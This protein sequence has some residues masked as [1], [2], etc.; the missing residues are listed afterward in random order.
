[1]TVTITVLEEYLVSFLFVW[2]NNT[3][4][5][6]L[7]MLSNVWWIMLEMIAIPASVIWP[8]SQISMDVI[9][10]T[11][12][13]R[14]LPRRTRSGTKRNCLTIK[15]LY[16]WNLLFVL[17]VFSVVIEGSNTVNFYRSNVHILYFVF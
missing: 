10:F 16:A 3:Q 7:I 9:L 14:K 5:M 6:I 13:V 15:N 8:M 4:I 17:K 11:E 1:M 2:Q 12:D